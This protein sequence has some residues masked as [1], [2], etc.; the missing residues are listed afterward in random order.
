MRFFSIIHLY[1]CKLATLESSQN[2]NIYFMSVKNNR[3]ERCYA[4]FM[5]NNVSRNQH[6]QGD[7]RFK[8]KFLY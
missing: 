6:V 2:F 3:F 8:V 5:Y 1:L 7:V 4:T